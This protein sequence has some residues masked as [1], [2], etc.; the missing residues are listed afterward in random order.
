MAKHLHTWV[1]G[2]GGHTYLKHHISNGEFD[3]F[4]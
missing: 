1:L 2:G 4:L 3:T